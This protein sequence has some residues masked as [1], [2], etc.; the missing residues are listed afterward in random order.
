VE[1]FFYISVSDTKEFFGHLNLCTTAKLSAVHK[2]RLQSR[3]VVQYRHFANKGILQMWTSVLFGAKNFKFFQI[4]G[5]STR[6]SELSQCGYFADKGGRSIFHDLVLMSF[7]F[8]GRPFRL[9]QN[10]YII[11]LKFY[12]N[13]LFS[14]V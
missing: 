1:K 10:D 12:K 3:G 13:Y 14:S 11:S 8:Y 6:T 9:F 7:I 2:R 5:V 4:Y